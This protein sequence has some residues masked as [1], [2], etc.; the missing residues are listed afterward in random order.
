MQE[1]L[2]RYK[3]PLIF[4]LLGFILAVLL[5]T[6]GFFK[7]LLIIILTGLGMAIGQYID[8]NDLLKKYFN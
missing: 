8:N 6:I 7:T 3:V 2:N 4:G 5:V 1:W